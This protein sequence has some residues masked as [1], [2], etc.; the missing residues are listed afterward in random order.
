M[1]GYA[2]R[3]LKCWWIERFQAPLT[4]PTVSGDAVE[5]ALA[6]KS[7]RLKPLPQNYLAISLPGFYPGRSCLSGVSSN[8]SVMPSC[9]HDQ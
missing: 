1:E 5:G 2:A 6:A 4:H 7:S 3:H 9:S 8:A